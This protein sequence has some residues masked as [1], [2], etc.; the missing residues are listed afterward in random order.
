MQLMEN[1]CLIMDVDHHKRM[2]E[3]L[4]ATNSIAS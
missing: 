2:E 3:K 4:L 1:T